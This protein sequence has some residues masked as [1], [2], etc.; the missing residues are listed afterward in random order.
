MAFT[1]QT[2]EALFLAL[3][4]I[5]SALVEN[6]ALKIEQLQNA[7]TAF[8]MQSEQTLIEQKKANTQEAADFMAIFAGIA[9]SKGKLT[10][11]HLR[12]VQSDDEEPS[13]P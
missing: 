5:V 2:D 6:G 13:A 12:L 9:S 7:E 4:T 8:R 11:P 3:S 1:P 10:A